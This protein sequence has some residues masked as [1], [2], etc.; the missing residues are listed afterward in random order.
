MK[1]MILLTIT[2]LVLLSCVCIESVLSFSGATHRILSYYAASN[3]VL[4][5]E[6]YL[7]NYLGF[8]EGLLEPLK[9]EGKSQRIIV[10]MQDGSDLEDEGITRSYNHFHNPLKEWANAGLD[11][12]LFGFHL[13]GKSSLIWA[14]DGSNQ[15]TFPGGDWSWQKTRDL[16]Y[17]A[18]TTATDTGRQQYFA[19]TFRGLGHQIH[20]IQ[21]M[22]VPEHARNDAHPEQSLF[23]YNEFRE[24]Y[25][26]PWAAEND[27]FITQYAQNPLPPTVS[28]NTKIN[29]YVP[30]TQLTD[31]NQ[32]DGSN[33]STSTAIGLSEYTNANFFSDDTIFAAEAI[34]FP[35]RPWHYFPYPKK[36]S[37]NIETYKDQLPETK[38]ER[39]GVE[40]LGFWIAKERDG[41]NIDHFLKPTYHTYDLHPVPGIEQIYYRTFYRDEV[42]HGD[43][44]SKLVPRAVGYSAGLL[45]YFFRG[46]IEMVDD[47]DAGGYVIKNN[48]EEDMEGKFELYYDATDNQRKQC[49]SDSF[50][51]G[52]LS[53]G[54]NKSDTISFTPP[55]DAKEPGKYI[56]VFQGRLGNEDN[57]VVGAL[58]S[59]FIKIPFPI[60]TEI[61]KSK[62]DPPPQWIRGNFYYI[63]SSG[64]GGASA[65]DTIIT[66]SQGNTLKIN[67][68]KMNGLV[69][70]GNVD[71]KTTGEPKTW[72]LQLTPHSDNPPKIKIEMGGT[73]N[74][75]YEIALAVILRDDMTIREKHQVGGSYFGDVY[76]HCP[77]WNYYYGM[78]CPGSYCA[79]SCSALRVWRSTV[80]INRTDIIAAVY[81]I[82]HDKWYQDS[83]YEV[84]VSK[85]RRIEGYDGTI[86]SLPYPG[87]DV[88]YGGGQIKYPPGSSS[89]YYNWVIAPLHD[90]YFGPGAHKCIGYGNYAV[91]DG[92]GTCSYWGENFQKRDRGYYISIAL[93]ADG[94]VQYLEYVGMDSYE[95]YP[96]DCGPCGSCDFG[97]FNW[98]PRGS[99]RDVKESGDAVPGLDTIEITSCLK[100]GSLLYGWLTEHGYSIDVPKTKISIPAGNYM[101][102]PF[103]YRY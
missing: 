15:S 33:P 60:Q 90:D 52:T 61:D 57:A 23:Q 56:L 97:D 36:A 18:L 46:K 75:A 85:H 45:D 4:N 9:W 89:Y 10:W 11:D 17:A 41:E 25:F 94:M 37:T 21:D 92:I 65:Q 32:Y 73:I 27:I 38:T 86:Y 81:R 34:Y 55:D 54:N 20:L 12:Y 68:F 76:K 62:G 24:L 88:T 49:W 43:Y 67:G 79:W 59:L 28:L 64:G 7:F 1:R 70:N 99:L 72:E 22:G 42:C 74:L 51:L 84:G 19:M 77:V 63:S 35:P 48:L 101:G 71:F 91:L 5:K 83:P 69:W 95:D 6:N 53:S 16:Y 26:E 31:A 13:S 87:P 39:D 40:D 103:N 96:K 98:G 50:A 66:F 30:I 2:I 29:N 82:S 78:C 3:S 80:Y 102:D 47:K 14:Q 93:N 8:Q 44:A 100:E 58:T